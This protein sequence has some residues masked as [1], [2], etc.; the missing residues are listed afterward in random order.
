MSAGFSW[1]QRNTG[2]HRPPLQFASH[3]DGLVCVLRIAYRD[4]R[5]APFSWQYSSALAACSPSSH[6]TTISIAGD[7]PSGRMDMLVLLTREAPGTRNGVHIRGIRIHRWAYFTF[8]S[9]H[10]SA[11]EAWRRYRD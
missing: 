2:G 8:P 7:L 9:K 11:E 4:G 6:H 10:C 5:L 1:N 3:H